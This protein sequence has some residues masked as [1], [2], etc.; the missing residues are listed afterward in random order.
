[1]K[2]REFDE[3]IRQKFDQGDFE[4]NPASWEKLE[5]QMDRKATRR[6]IMM[7]LPLAPIAY[8]SSVAASLAMI[9]T[10]PVLMQHSVSRNE[11]PAGLVNVNTHHNA[12]QSS[13]PVLTGANTLA[14]NNNNIQYSK[15]EDKNDQFHLGLDAIKDE[16]T[17]NNSVHHSDRSKMSRSDFDHAFAYDGYME[18]ATD[19]R[20]NSLPLTF[21]IIGGYNTGSGMNGFSVGANGKKML[22]DRFYVEGDVTFIDNSGIQNK[23]DPSATTSSMGTPYAI[24][25]PDNTGS[26]NNQVVASNLPVAQVV[27]NLPSAGNN[28]NTG[29]SFMVARNTMRGARITSDPGETGPT[30]VSPT[31]PVQAMPNIHRTRY[32]LYYAQVSPAIGY[33]LYKNLSVGVG[34]DVQR[35]LQGDNSMSTS[36][37]ATTTSDIAADSKL[38]PGF[39]I[40]L[41]GKTEVTLSDK[42]RASIYYRQGMNNV[43]T[44]GSKYIDRSYLQIHLKFTLFKK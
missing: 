42:I 7:W 23:L 14:V 26:G 16:L 19:S 11:M 41:V 25:V 6:K 44:P 22:N 33:H 37:S 43:I 4:Y 5:G 3:L 27:P 20:S 24:P 40:G 21:S 9:I 29:N 8:I 30:P 10:I 34:A 32:D 13:S 2:P 39:D 18:N 38:V 35:L 15:K 1:M 17:N 36:T 12:Q 28:T 31:A